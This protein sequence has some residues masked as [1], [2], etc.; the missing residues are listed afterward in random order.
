[1]KYRHLFSFALSFGVESLTLFG[2]SPLSVDDLARIAQNK[3]IGSLDDSKFVSVELVASKI[4]LIATRT[5]YLFPVPKSGPANVDIFSN[6]NPEFMWR[7]ELVSLDLL[8]EQY[9]ATVKVAR[10]TR[11]KVKNHEKAVIKLIQA[12]NG[13]MVSIKSTSSADK[14]QKLIAKVSVE[15]EKVLKY[16]REEEKVRLLNDTKILKEKQKEMAKKQKDEEKKRL[17]EDKRKE[18][19]KAE[20]AKK[21]EKALKLEENDSKR[22]KALEKKAAE[23][24]KQKSRLMSFFQGAATPRHVEPAKIPVCAPVTLSV[25]KHSSFDSEKFWSALGSGE[26]ISNPFADSLSKQAKRSRK[27]K[28]GT[29]NVRVFVPTVSDNPFEQQVY[30]E[31]KSL[32]IRNRYKFLCFREDFRP[33]YHGTWSKPLSTLISGR[34]PYAK[35]TAYL[36]YDVDSEE[37]WEEGDDEQ[38]EDCSENGN[39]DE[40]MVDDE[41]G[42]ITMYN[43]Q[44]GWLAEDGDLELEDD[45]EESQ[46]LRKRKVEDCNSSDAVGTNLNSK[47]AAAFVIA[48]LKGGIP[49]AFAGRSIVPDS[50]EGIKTSE[51][52]R[53]LKLHNGETLSSESISLDPFPPSA[54]TASKK[55]ESSSQKSPSNEMS[56]DDLIKFAKFVHNSKLKSKDMVV[57]ELRNTHCDITSSRAQATRKLDSIA[58]KHRLKNGGGVIWEVKNEILASLG[59]H[60]LVKT[61]EPDDAK[62]ELIAKTAIDFKEKTTQESKDAN[63]TKGTVAMAPTITPTKDKIETKCTSTTTEADTKTTTQPVKTTKSAFSEKSV[64]AIVSPSACAQNEKEQETSPS[65]KRK[66]APVSKSSMN[67]LTS[68]LKKKKTSA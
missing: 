32:P 66:A 57:E 20:E 48:P 33:P 52:D 55:T 62:P 40:E 36:D 53:V 31:E 17:E 58:R 12:I 44:D 46:E 50:V 45:D 54:K 3:L 6:T 27:R 39:D 68:F 23:E 37:E 38:G 11:R 60:D 56:R 26:E 5:Q 2:Y 13:V 19:L 21:V 65:R 14:K 49:Q 30:D 10:S 25:I 7:W 1:V 43:Y 67:L 34:N 41:E 51:A 47:F 63:K 22:T 4:K 35:D 59:L 16:E 61:E 28:V 8:P 9:K 18:K 15:E 64:H 24:M 42:D 29:T